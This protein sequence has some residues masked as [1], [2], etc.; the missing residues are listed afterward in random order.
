MKAVRRRGEFMSRVTFGKVPMPT[1]QVL[2][3]L[4]EYCGQD[5]WAC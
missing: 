4:E 1:Q 5:T 3:N 2:R